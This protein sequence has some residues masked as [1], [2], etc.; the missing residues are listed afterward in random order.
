MK[1]LIGAGGIM[2]K[3]LLALLAVAGSSAILNAEEPPFH[4]TR[5][6]AHWDQYDHPDYLPFLEDAQPEVAQVGFYGAHFWSLVHTPHYG[7]YPAHFPVRGIKACGAWFERLNKSL[8]ER[9]IRSV[10]HFNIEFLVGD[11][12]GPDGPRGFFKWYRDHWDEALLGPKPVADPVDFLEK[13]AEGAPIVNRSYAIGGMNEY[14]ACLRNPAWQKVL[15]AWVRLGIARGVDGFIV[16]YFYRH[17]CLCT[18]CQSGFRAYLASRYTAEDLATRFGISD[19]KEHRFEEI[20]SWHAPSESSPIRREMLRFSQ[21]SNKQVFDRVFVEH[22]RKLKSDLI[23][24][25]WNH[26]GNF[27]AISG[28]ERC[29]LPAEHWGKDE[30]YVWY[31]TGGAANFT[32][33]SNRFLGDAVLQARYVRGAFADKP[34]TLGKYENTRTRVAIAELA[35]NGGAPMGF[36]TRFTDPDARREIVRYYQFLKRHDA[37]F[38]GNRPHAEVVLVYPRSHVHRGEL[39]ALERFRKLGRELLDRHVLFDV[40]PDDLLDA[41]ARKRYRAVVR[42]G[43]KDERPDGLSQFEAPY[44][45]RVSGSRPA[46]GKGEIDL[47]FVNYDREEPP[48]GPDGKPSPGSGIQDEKPVP[49]PEIAVDF[50][51]PAGSI[52]QAVTC[53]TPERADPNTLAWEQEGSRIR[54]SV[55]PFD[56]YAVIR[57]THEPE[58]P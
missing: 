58:A 35:A 12:D 38:R 54:F 46:A 16:N 29:L 39:D 53:L 30:T 23:L 55:P 9:R 21:I 33:L 51:L 1:L 57:V 4:F 52:A 50:A 43:E 8:H 36:Y 13:N 56:V 44:T 34:F 48:S 27:D 32:D 22:G 25:Q 15:E 20:V 6:V 47:H 31:S 42:A 49:T 7:G 26:L 40:L 18:H 10:G 17:D 2:S 3:R 37:L 41:E 45:V 19:L 11:P 24:A 14:W 28:D 5:M